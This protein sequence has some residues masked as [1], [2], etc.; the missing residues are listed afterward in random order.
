MTRITKGPEEEAEHKERIKV[1]EEFT[2]KKVSRVVNR[3]LTP[4]DDEQSLCFQHSVI[5]QTGLPYRDPGPKVLE[6]RRDQ[7]AASL[8]LTAGKVR[9]PETGDWEHLGLPSGTKARLVLAHLNAEALRQKSPL[10]EVEESLSAFV[11]RIRGFNNGREITAFKKQLSRLAS[12]QISLSIIHNKRSIQTDSKI[13]HKFDLWLEKDDRQRVLWPSTIQLSKDYFDSLQN[14][15]VPLNE[16]DIAA[17]SHSAMALDIYA[18]L[19]QRLHRIPANQPARISWAALSAQFG[20][21]YSRQRAFRVEFT[22]Q[23]RAVKTRYFSADIDLDE[24]G[25]IASCSPPPVAKRGNII[26]AR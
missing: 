25:M 16:S 17:L 14:H 22:E 10:I 12:A 11:R 7:G 23:L 6:W 2:G 4:P 13:I 1:V 18:W 15:A 21:G 19:A 8:L 20:Y 5:C 24:N 3:L 26:A 9:N